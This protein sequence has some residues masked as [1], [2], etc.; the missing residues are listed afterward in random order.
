MITPEQV[1]KTLQNH[2]KLGRTP[3]ARIR[4]AIQHVK[5]R[6]FDGLAKR[7]TQ[8]NTVLEAPTNT[9]AD[10]HVCDS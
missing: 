8:K 6:A 9:E 4:D 3:D 1:Y 10:C 7:L 2:Q 5:G